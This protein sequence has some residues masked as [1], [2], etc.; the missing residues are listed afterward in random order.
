MPIRSLFFS[1][2]VERIEKSVAAGKGTWSDE[3]QITSWAIIEM[4]GWDMVSSG[5][6]VY[7][8]SSS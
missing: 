7:E 5:N 6:T 3:Q 8:I 4:D 2:I 1:F